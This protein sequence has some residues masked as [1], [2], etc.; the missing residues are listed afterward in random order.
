MNIKVTIEC[1]CGNDARY[2]D[3]VTDDLVCSLCAMKSGNPATRLSDLPDARIIELA[4]ESV[5]VNTY[6]VIRNL[7]RDCEGIA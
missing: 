3:H 2:L 5:Q 6:V 1:N 7:I 4:R